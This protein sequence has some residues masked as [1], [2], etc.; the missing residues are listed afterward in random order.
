MSCNLNPVPLQFDP[1]MHLFSTWTCKG[2]WGEVGGGGG[3]WGAVGHGIWPLVTFDVMSNPP[4]KR[5]VLFRIHLKGILLL[6]NPD[7][8]NS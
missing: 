2:D 7:V 5:V 8:L 3:G 6:L 1:H 4:W